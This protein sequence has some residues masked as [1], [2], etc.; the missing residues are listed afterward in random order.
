MKTLR[1]PAAPAALAPPTLARLLLPGLLLALALVLA[2]ARPAAALVDDELPHGLGDPAVMEALGIVSWG[3]IPF[4]PEGVKD[5]ATWGSS[6]DVVA[7]LVASEWV[8]LETRRFR[9]ISSLDKMNVSAKDRERLEPWFEVLRAAGVDLAKRPKKLD[10][11]LRLVTMALRAEALYDRFLELVGK[12]DEDFYPS[13]AE[14]G[15]GP[16]MG[17][18]PYLGEM[19]KFEL[20]VHRSARTHQQWTF[21]HMGTTVTGSLRWKFRDPGRL[22]GSLPASDSDLEH[23]R[24]LWPHTAHVLGHMFLA[25]Y[26]HFSYDPPVWLDEGVALLLEREANPESITTEG[27]EGTLNEHI[28]ASD[29]KGELAKLARKGEPRTAELMTRRTSGAMSELDLVASWSRVQFLAGEH[30]EAF[31]RFLG[32]L[33]GQLDEAG[34][35]TG[36]DL[37]GLQ[38]R[39]LKEC[40]GWS[41]ADLD[42][43]WLAWLR[44][45]DEDD[46]GEG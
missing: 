35:P 15:D 10:P 23:D 39:A 34:Y 36:N 32:I 2:A 38:R 12:T 8:A 29:W 17:N 7:N 21:A 44:G 5:G 45:E 1:P 43:A 41:P 42:A 16:Y 40:F 18:G 11:H 25:A 31:A 6:D 9:W 30:P 28:G 20:I 3:P 26:K 19:D 14:Q 13:R 37:D 46:E 22:H 4:G 27:M 33:K 24:W